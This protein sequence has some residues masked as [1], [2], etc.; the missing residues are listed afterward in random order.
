MTIGKKIRQLRRTR[1]WTL[2]D[3]AKRSGVALS[4]L[5]RME[6]GRMTGTLESHIR[7]TRALGVRLP[8]L[9]ADL[10]AGGSPLEIRRNS[11]EADRLGQ[12]K[13]AWLTA[14]ATGISQKK[15]LPVLVRLQPGRSTR[16]Q[17]GPVGTERWLYLLKGKLEIVA[18]QEQ[19]RLNKGDSLYLQG[20]LPYQL[21]NVGHGPA[22]AL[23]VSSPPAL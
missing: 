17:Q 14:L 2:A 19:V 20:S 15:M 4:S 12:G 18:G 16:Q 11:E 9:Y 23:S 13:G 3:L 1:D 22:L 8:E 6:T 10:D 5:S 21:K 7:I